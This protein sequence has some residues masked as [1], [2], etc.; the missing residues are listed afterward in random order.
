[1]GGI[2]A[3]LDS[4]NKNKIISIKSENNQLSKEQTQKIIDYY[5]KYGLYRVRVNI[6]NIDKLINNYLKVI[7]NT[8]NKLATS[9][10]HNIKFAT[11]IGIM[12]ISNTGFSMLLDL[13]PKQIEGFENIERFKNKTSK[14]SKKRKNKTSKKRI[15]NN[16][17]K[18]IITS[19]QIIKTESKKKL[20]TFQ[21]NNFDNFEII[22]PKI[23][24]SNDRR[25]F[26]DFILKNIQNSSIK[27]KRLY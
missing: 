26:I 25:E 15:N 22:I 9:L 20:K 2:V 14:R 7:S 4:K 13:N 1:M 6:K 18:K 21:S 11:T 24:L 3:K 5:N 16:I 23:L 12:L 27:R 17:N 8:D 10:E 19:T